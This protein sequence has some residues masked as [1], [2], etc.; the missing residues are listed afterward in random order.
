MA[1]WVAPLA[2]DRWRTVHV[3][4]ESALRALRVFQVCYSVPASSN[5]LARLGDQT[6]AKTAKTEKSPLAAESPRIKKFRRELI[7]SIPRFPN[8]RASLQHMQQKHLA[9]L[10]I[11]YINWR[12]RYVGQRP[13]IVSIEPAAQADP[14]WTS[15]AAAIAAFLDKVRKGDD[16]TPH[17]SIEPHTKGYRPAAHAPNATPADRW[18]DKDFVLN[19]MG[20]HHFHLGTNIQRRG[21]VDRTGDLIFAEVQRDT[22]NVIAIFGHEVFDSNSAESSRLWSVHDQVVCRGVP[23][24]SVVIPAMIANSGHALK[25][26][27]YAQH[28]AK[29]IRGF[30]PKL[31]DWTYMA[32]LYPQGR[33]MSAKPEFAWGFDHLD[34]LIHEAV[35]PINLVLT[36]GW[37]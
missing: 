27:Q 22:L 34:L 30:E 2:V 8:D 24:G 3:I 14:R 31:D 6:L 32:R 35:A 33:E 37:N 26:V 5:V 36:K 19:V 25:V 17:L 4:G 28:C 29:V 13:R 7:N 1:P 21:H 10:L 12:S 23:P 11:D 18:S 9:A 15:H 20:C 16:L